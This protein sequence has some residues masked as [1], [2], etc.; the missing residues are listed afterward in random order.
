MTLLI[1]D[2][3]FENGITDIY[4]E[5]NRIKTIKPNLQ[6]EA[7]TTLN[8]KGMA[9]IPGFINAHTHSAMTLFRGFGDD[10]PLET[11]LS[12]KIWPNEVNLTEELVYWGSKLACLEMIKGG[13]TFFCDMYWYLPATAR[14]VSEMGLRASLSSVL[15]DVA[16]AA[17]G[18]SLKQQVE[19]RIAEMADFPETISLS[20]APH[21]IYTASKEL[22]QWAKAKADKHGLQLHIHLSET[23]TEVANSI[24]DFGCRPVE[25]L[26]KIGFL[27]PNVIVA[28]ALWLSDNDINI[29]A[30]HNVK[31]V[32]NPASNLK[33]ASGYKFRYPD[34]KA[35]GVTVGLATDGV[36]SNNNL[37]MFEAMKYASLLQK[38]VWKNPTLLPVDET[39]DLST[40][41][42]GIIF[43]QDMGVI[44]EGAL[45]DFSLV[46]LD[47]PTLVPSH[48]LISNLVYSANVGCV[49]TVICN[50]KIIMQN[51]VVPGEKEIIQQARKSAEI[52]FSLNNS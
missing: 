28:H 49:D 35:A 26:E 37:S 23:E 33:L 19:T 44:K 13:T 34:L 31:V 15:F 48:N 32:H 40:K 46:N 24:R 21:A 41:N 22:L 17:Q 5:G 43:N 11:W 6:I 52:L 27:G 42:G 1:K 38:S 29:F 16:G 2:V 3:L 12:E 47:D 39:F 36:S 20:I 30:K 9:A 51:R 10:L 14:A 45:A 18:E 8:G 7:K 50:G 4:V 25:Y